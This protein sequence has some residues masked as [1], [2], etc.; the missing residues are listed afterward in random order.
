MISYKFRW[1]L[2]ISIFTLAVMA[3]G[4]LSFRLV[5]PTSGP[6][7]MVESAELVPSPTLAEVAAQPTDIPT[8]EVAP[9]QVVNPD[10]PE[11]VYLDSPY[12]YYEQGIPVL[13]GGRLSVIPSPVLFELYWDY[14]SI[15]G[16]M[17]YSSAFFSSS[18][19]ES[20][21]PVSDLWVYDFETGEAEMWL[22]SDVRRAVWAP[23]GQALTISLFNH[24]T[25]QLDLALLSGPNQMEILAE[26]ASMIYSWSPD[27][28]R[29]AYLNPVQT[30]GIPD[31]CA[32]GYLV[33][34]SPG[35]DA[36]DATV[37]RFSDFSDKPL[38]GWSEGH[39]PVWALEQNALIFPSQPMW[40]IPLDGS[41]A[42][43]PQH[44]D[45]FNGEYLPAIEDQIWSPKTRQLVGTVEAGMSGR[46]GVWVFGLSPDLR[47]LT[48]LYRIED[49]PTEGNTDI[50]L[51]GWW[52]QGES[53]LLV[54]MAVGKEAHF[55]GE[56]WGAPA[57]WDLDDRT[58]DELI[59]E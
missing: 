5:T 30:N 35:V 49:I 7:T 53:V 50:S 59:F 43:T 45:V 19:E 18:G 57:V 15:S 27:G 25:Q 11:E 10:V 16:K 6:A 12:S 28:N 40:V 23:D 48:G 41:A 2:L 37:V 38:V 8:P 3:C 36:Q 44:A 9:T 22:S 51:F 34:T 14:S 1:M 31:R 13:D 52:T 17:A 54:D 55:L 24:D 20:Q 4:Q 32:G 26:C 47:T 33:S 46:G 42:F 29:I 58:W 56:W 39:Q 21:V